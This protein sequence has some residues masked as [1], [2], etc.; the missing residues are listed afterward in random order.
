MQTWCDAKGD[1]CLIT[2]W[3]VGWREVMWGWR[4]VM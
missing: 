1:K 2:E 3:N 4:E